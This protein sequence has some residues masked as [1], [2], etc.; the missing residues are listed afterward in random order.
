MEKNAYSDAYTDTRINNNDIFY[1]T[2]LGTLSQPDYKKFR[3]VCQRGLITY[4][5]KICK[6]DLEIFMSKIIKD[7]FRVCYIAHEESDVNNP[8]EHTHVLIDWYKKLD[9]NVLHF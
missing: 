7:G 1:E 3:Y 5:T 9:K 2:F 6:T 4:R 8:Y